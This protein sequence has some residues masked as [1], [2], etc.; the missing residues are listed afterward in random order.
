MSDDA[1]LVMPRLATPADEVSDSKPAN[2]RKATASHWNWQTRAWRSAVH[3]SLVSLDQGVLTLTDALESTTFGTPSADGVAAEITV[4]DPAL[5]S[6]VA[7]GGSIGAAESYMA[8][9]WSTNDLPAVVRLMIRNARVTGA[10]ERCGKWLLQPWLR[11]GHWLRRNNEQ[12]SKQNIAAHYDLGNDFYSLWLDE[13][14][15]YSS[16]VF[17]S[18]QATLA[19]AQIAKFDRLC[20]KLQL[21]PGDRVLEIGCGWGGLALHAARNYGCHVTGTTISREQANCV[22]ERVEQAGLAS[23]ITLLQQDYRAL[24]GEYDKLV[25]VEMIEAVGP[26]FLD[27]Y[28][29]TCSRLLKPGG[30]LVLQGITIADDLYKDYCRSVDFI[31]K[32]IFPGGHLPA[33]SPMLQA[34][35]EHTDLKLQQLD[36]LPQHYARTLAAWRSNFHAADEKL[37]QLGLPISFRRMWDFYFSYCEGGFREQQLGLVQMKLQKM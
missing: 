19:E 13:S 20:Q 28:F 29:R 4:H 8:G 37:A 25:S 33:V 16:A 22:R 9:E 7:L 24:T 1:G 17:E 34:I 18:P 5:Y 36:N 26:Q 31:Q 10:L 15:A 23:R 3:R 30:L 14:L 35:S 32:Y 6:R 21:Q 11:W 12:G 27:E 2:Q